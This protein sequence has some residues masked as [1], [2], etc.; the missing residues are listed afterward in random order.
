MHK[1]LSPIWNGPYANNRPLH[2]RAKELALETLRKEV[3]A[4][5]EE[6]TLDSTSSGDVS[7]PAA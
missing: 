6:V 3:A 1:P 2:D 4:L 7:G 5:E